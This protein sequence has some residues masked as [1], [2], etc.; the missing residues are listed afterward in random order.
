MF[1]W[2]KWIN[3]WIV[4][5]FLDADPAD[6]PVLLFKWGLVIVALAVLGWV[7]RRSIGF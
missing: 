4:Q 6:R 5:P 1:G 3:V 2:T 7:I